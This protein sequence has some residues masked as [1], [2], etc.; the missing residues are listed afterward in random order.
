M[1]FFEFMSAFKPLTVVLMV[2]AFIFVMGPVVMDAFI[3]IVFGL[4]VY[5]VIKKVL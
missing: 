4:T 3:P 1:E 2:L 5:Y